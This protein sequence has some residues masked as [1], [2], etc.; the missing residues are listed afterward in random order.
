MNSPHIRCALTFILA[1]AVSASWAQRRTLTLEESIVIGME[2]SRALHSSLL[3]S[4]AADARRQEYA[5]G[6]YPSMRIQA[7]YQKLSDVPAFAISIPGNVVSF[8]VVLNNYSMRAS[9]QQPLFTG[10]K[11]QG[12]ADNAEYASNAAKSDYVKD[13]AELVYSIKSAYWNLYRAKEIRHLSDENVNQIAQHLADVENLFKQG[14]ATTNEVL[15]VK[16]QLSNAKLMQNDAVNNVEILV[17]VLNSTLG[18]PLDIPVDVATAPSPDASEVADMQQLVTKAMAHRPDLQAM[19]WRLRASQSGVAAARAGWLP[20]LYLTGGFTYARPNPRIFPA[21]DEFKDTWDLGLTMQLDVWNNLTTVYQTDQAQAQYDQT[22]DAYAILKD[23]V[24]L[25]V[26]QNYLNWKQV[27]QKI[28]LARLGVEQADE[29]LRVTKEKFET[30]LTTNSELLDA[31]VAQL[32]ARLQ[33]VQ[34]LVDHELARAKLEKSVG[35][36]Q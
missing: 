30:G 1:L 35:E 10:W 18:I 17:L 34:S 19:E 22:N 33:H 8:P 5:A 27:Q 21:K 24:T 31:E 3:R 32:Q 23:A 25:E 13:K 11:L 9:V 14:M 7:G 28:G 20:Q 26:S 2:N 16:V 15:K 36:A 6:L 12:A 4:A 29:N